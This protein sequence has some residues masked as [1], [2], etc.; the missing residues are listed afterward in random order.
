MS[1]YYLDFLKIIIEG[2]GVAHPLYV[3]VEASGIHYGSN[4]I[5]HCILKQAGEEYNY[6]GFKTLS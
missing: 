6:S 5:L 2:R 1:Q 3:V 4:T